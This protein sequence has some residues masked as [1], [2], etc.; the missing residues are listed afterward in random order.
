MLFGAGKRASP[1]DAQAFDATQI[2]QAAFYLAASAVLSQSASAANVA[3]VTA[4]GAVLSQ[5]TSVANVA[6]VSNVQLDFSEMPLFTMY[7]MPDGTIVCRGGYTTVL[8]HREYGAGDFSPVLQ[9]ADD[10]TESDGQNTGDTEL[11]QDIPSVDPVSPETPSEQSPDA[12]A[13]G[14]VPDEE[15]PDGGDELATEDFPPVA[16]DTTVA[17]DEVA[18]QV[19]EDT[20]LPDGTYAD[21]T[22]W[23]ADDSEDL[24]P[25]D[26][27]H[28][29]EDFAGSNSPGEDG[30]PVSDVA[31]VDGDEVTEPISDDTAVPDDTYAD[32]AGSHAN[33]YEDL[34]PVDSEYTD[35]E[36][37]VVDDGS[38]ENTSESAVV[39]CHSDDAVVGADGSGLMSSGMAEA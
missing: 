35:E 34:G 36:F 31:P 33:E 16:D 13:V 3:P 20:G 2:E 25:V 38:S 39:E 18:E 28:A 26:T 14:A 27:E 30:S 12:D 9:P 37:P 32:D 17:G 21:D 22:S 8:R 29:D 7:Q 15:Q 6:P 11:T 19:F 1:H 10:G 24:S 5:S 23:Y 4:A